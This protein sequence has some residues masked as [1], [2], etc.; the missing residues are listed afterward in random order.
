MA[1]NLVILV[2]L[3]H[4][5]NAGVGN[6]CIVSSLN[7]KFLL[8]LQGSGREQNI[9][10]KGKNTVALNN[11]RRA[12]GLLNLCSNGLLGIEEVDLAVC[13]SVLELFSVTVSK[14]VS[15]VAG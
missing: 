2:V 11:S 1:T 3:V 12:L 15:F 8:A 7:N 13:K 14:Y 6:G 9:F 4:L 10:G 5:F